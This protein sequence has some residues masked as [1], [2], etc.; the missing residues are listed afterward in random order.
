MKSRLEMQE[1]LEGILGS[2]HVYF[3]SPPNTGMEYPAIVYSFERYEIKSADNIPY[4]A[5]GRW[6]IHHIYKSIKNDL[7]EKFVFGNPMFSFDRRAVS[8]GVYNDYYTIII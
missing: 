6:Q 2:D 3:Q 7:K 8:N 5:A 1:I 4:I